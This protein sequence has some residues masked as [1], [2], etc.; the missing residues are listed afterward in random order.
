[1]SFCV[2]RNARRRHA[3]RRSIEKVEYRMAKCGLVLEGGGMRGIYTAGILD[4]LGE[5]GVGF[6]GV[7]GVSA[8]AI[9]GASFLAGQHGRSIRLYLG[10]CRDPR[11]M[12]VKSWLVTGNIVNDDFCYREVPENLVPFDYDA[13]EQNDVPFYIVATDI[14]SGQP[15]YMLTKSLKGDAMR[16]MRA[17]ASLPFVSS[18]VEFDGKRLLDGG[19]S[20]SIPIRFMMKSG[21]EKNVIILTQVD[22]YRK[23]PEMNK[24][25]QLRY[26]QYPQYLDAMES[27][28]NRYNAVLDEIRELESAQSAFV[29]RPSHKIKIRRLERSSTRILAMY[30]LGRHDALARL[31]ALKAFM[32]KP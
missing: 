9:H 27:R 17:S 12:G 29:F 30:E 10:F 22:G 21:Y 23:K 4:V 18:V 20:D 31:D 14:D 32:A 5:H 15:H 11:F 25:Y 13:F 28:H 24:L 2:P 26:R 3:E 19:T 16:A 1:M 8:G 7:V 6:D